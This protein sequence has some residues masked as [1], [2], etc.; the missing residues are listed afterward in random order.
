MLAFLKANYQAGTPLTISCTEG[1]FTGTLVSVSHDAIVLQLPN[2]TV[3]GIAAADI[4]TFSAPS[5]I[6]MQP[7]PGHTFA[8][9][10]PEQAAE[11][12]S[13]APADAAGDV[14]P[15]DSDDITVAP[16]EAAA[17]AEPTAAVKVVGRIPLDQL[18]RIDPK[19]AR[20][21]YFRSP[22]A[23]KAEKPAPAE[24][25]NATTTPDDPADIYVGPMGRITYYN[26]ASR[27]GFIRDFHS[28]TDRY[29]H[30]SQVAEPQLIDRLMKGI[31]V[32]YTAD[33]NARG[34]QARC[35][36]LPHTIDELLDLTDENIERGYYQLAYDI[37]E[38]VLQADPTNADAL[39]MR[40]EVLSLLPNRHA[41]KGVNPSQLEPTPT[42]VEAKNAFLEKNF[43]QADKL[44]REAI[45]KGERVGSAVKDLLQIYVMRY[46]A[47]F[48]MAD[49]DEIRD[50]A[51][52]AYEEY[53]DKLPDDLSTL[54]YLAGNF[55]LPLQLYSRY[56]TLTEQLLARPEIQDENGKRAF[57]IWQ[58]AMAYRRLG[59]LDEAIAEAHRGIA[60]SPNNRNLRTLI[61]QLEAPEGEEAEGAEAE[62]DTPA[63]PAPEAVQP[64]APE[65]EASADN[66]PA[67]D[68]ADTDSPDSDTATVASEEEE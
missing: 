63:Q 68:D 48:S 65:A 45:D 3:F 5:P 32:V 47:A 44:F 59:R 57:Y 50:A 54:Q 66:A 4:H 8:Q 61:E 10:A 2:G 46:K 27:Y 13:A 41:F 11:A 24:A 35:V 36:H 34:Q 51:L 15:S 9:P 60:L 62:E 14:A 20:R 49:H 26:R 56:L 64:E 19:S 23:E 16:S 43:E 7:V 31:K 39:D 6:P 22:S 1:T 21:D 53:R 52:E 38:H 37:L 42:Y 33:V 58:R 17:E 40:A 28:E 29:F 18:R 30:L 12:A 25:E 67:A 55:F